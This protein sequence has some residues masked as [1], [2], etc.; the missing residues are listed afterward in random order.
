MC[1]FF[2]KKAYGFEEVADL[3]NIKIT[4]YEKLKFTFHT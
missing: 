4:W 3:R 1:F 2:I